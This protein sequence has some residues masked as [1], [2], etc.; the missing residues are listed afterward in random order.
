[1]PACRERR[2]DAQPGRAAAFGAALPD[3]DASVACVSLKGWVQLT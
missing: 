3:G 2:P 1:M